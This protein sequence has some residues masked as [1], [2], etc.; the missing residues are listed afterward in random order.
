MAIAKSTHKIGTSRGE[1]KRRIWLEGDRVLAA[2][3][4][5]GMY[6]TREWREDG[7]L[8]LTLGEG[9]SRSTRGK[10]S[11]KGQ[12]PILDIVGEKV[13]EVFGSVC[14]RVEVEYSAGRIVVRR[15]A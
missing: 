11:G 8:V 6:Y 3:F 5:V 4:A 10:V 15:A 1:P 9:E 12:R 2:G 7:S 14:E 13:F